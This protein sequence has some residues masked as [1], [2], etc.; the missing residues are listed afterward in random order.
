MIKKISF[1]F[2]PFLLI[3]PVFAQDSDF[4]AWKKKEAESFKQFKDA[5]DKAFI[6][7]LRADWKAF[8]AS[9]GEK[10]DE[11]PKPKKIPIAETQPNRNIIGYKKSNKVTETTK[12]EISKA[13]KAPPKKVAEPVAEEREN[14]NFSEA[15]FYGSPFAVSYPKKVPQSITSKVTSEL[16]AKFY[17]SMASSQY[18]STLR[19]ALFYKRWY[20]LNDWGFALLLSKMALQVYP[21]STD[22]RHLFVWFFLLK[23]GFDARVGYDDEGVALMLP[24]ENTMYATPYFTIDSKRFYLISFEGKPAKARSLYTYEGKNP[25]SIKLINLSFSQPLLLKPSSQ[26]RRLSF[27]YNGEKISFAV[28]YNRS[29]VEFLKA[30]PQTNIQLYFDSKIPKDLEASLLGALQPYLTG[31]TEAEAANFLLRFVQKA[32]QYKT[33]DDQFGYEKYFFPEESIFYPYC[34]CEDRS[35]LYAYLIRKLIGLEVVGLDYPGHIATAVKFSSPL[36]GDFDKLEVNGDSYIIC[37]PTY[38]NADIGM[39]MPNL[40]NTVPTIIPLQAP[41]RAR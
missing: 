33:D 19:Q 39:A 2:I 23:S 26:V 40:K 38:I 21:K 28:A 7:F 27:E 29:N 31:K 5:E 30:Y 10:P 16:I 17:E 14:F 6:G 13:Y 34:D 22:S 3:N 8:K 18:D 4:E 25:K 11:T 37:D 20:G 41:N 9:L 24:S 32:F 15:A 36:E 1:L 12:P 35:I